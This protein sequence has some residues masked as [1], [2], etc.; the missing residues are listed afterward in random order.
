MSDWLQKM[1]FT[2]SATVPTFLSLGLVGIIKDSDSY[3]KGFVDFAT[4][5]T[6]PVSFEWWAITGCFVL[7]ILTMILMNSYLKNKRR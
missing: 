6:L 5:C 4:L 2:V 1:L 3:L 7:F